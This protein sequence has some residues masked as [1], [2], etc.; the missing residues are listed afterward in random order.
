MKVPGNGELVPTGGGDAIPLIREVLTLG[1]RESCDIIMRFPNV[2]GT[3]C[4]LSFRAGYWILRDL[5]STNGVKVN[6][7]RVLKK[8]LQPGDTVTIAKRKFTIEY[9]P[10]RGTQSLDEIMEEHEDIDQP[11]LEKAGLVR[12]SRPPRKP[13]PKPTNRKKK[14]RA[15]EKE[16]EGEK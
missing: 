12:A 9:T 4:E 6:G 16:P 11:L 8:V 13:T 3:H 7:S 2:S 1:R 15:V 5:G 10:V 14:S